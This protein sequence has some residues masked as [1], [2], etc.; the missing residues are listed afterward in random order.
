M[1]SRPHRRGGGVALLVLVLLVVGALVAPAPGSASDA[2]VRAGDRRD[3]RRSVTVA[4]DRTQVEVGRVLVVRGRVTPAV[5]R[6]LV[7]V[8]KQLRTGGRWVT[9]AQVR[10][11]AD[12]RYAYRDR[13]S[14][15]GRRHY[16]VVVPA[17]ARHERLRTRALTVTV[18]RAHFL[19]DLPVQVQ[20][21]TTAGSATIDGTTYPHSSVG[22]ADVT[23]GFVQWR[24]ARRC[25]GIRFAMGAAD[26]SAAGSSA[27]TDVLLD[28]LYYFR[29]V[30]AAGDVAAPRYLRIG[31]KERIRFAWTSQAGGVD[32]AGARAVLADTVVWCAF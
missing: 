29:E 9:E 13:P 30:H 7:K 27:R 20:E 4:V 25:R 31:T 28:G 24:V 1:P 32:A 14:T 26:D 6:T 21:S 5:A 2:A 18:Y 19:A 10:T 8:Q 12:G 17:T 16:R 15:P 22:A 3:A 23:T 11:R